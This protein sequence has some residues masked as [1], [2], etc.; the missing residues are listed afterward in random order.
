MVKSEAE[1]VKS[2]ELNHPDPDGNNVSHRFIIR[3]R[4]RADK[5]VFTL[6]KQTPTV[7]Y[8]AII[9]PLVEKCVCNYP[10]SFWKPIGKNETFSL[11]SLNTEFIGRHSCS[12]WAIAKKDI[13]HD[14]K[15]KMNMTIQFNE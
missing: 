1:E 3:C 4:P 5:L 10:L 12:R 7:G 9:S 13:K 6:E 2:F 11:A 15:F 8:F 14:L